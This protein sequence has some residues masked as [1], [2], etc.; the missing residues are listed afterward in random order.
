MGNLNT[1]ATNFLQ[2]A[3]S[4]FSFM[5]PTQYPG[6]HLSPYSCFGS[7]A[8]KKHLFPSTVWSK[9][10]PGMDKGDVREGKEKLLLSIRLSLTINLHSPAPQTQD[11]L[12]TPTHPNEHTFPRQDTWCWGQAGISVQS[13]CWPLRQKAGHTTASSEWGFLPIVTN[14]RDPQPWASPAADALKTR[15]VWLWLCR[16]EA[17][18]ASIFSQ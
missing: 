4:F 17:V 3:L 10:S 8:A 15:L 2:K 13:K 12:V 5:C 18:R 9:Q 16:P 1:W 11:P 14:G 6:S 7:R